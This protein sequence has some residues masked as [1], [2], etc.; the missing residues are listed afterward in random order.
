MKIYNNIICLYVLL[1][2]CI[3]ITWAHIIH[4]YSDHNKEG[5]IDIY[6]LKLLCIRKLREMITDH[7][8][9]F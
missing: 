4:V 5:N 7:L 3:H 2:H 9:M 8:N 6:I 1:L